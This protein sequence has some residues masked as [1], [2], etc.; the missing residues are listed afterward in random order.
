MIEQGAILVS[1][2][3]FGAVASILACGV[4]WSTACGPDG[5]PREAGS[6]GAVAIPEAPPP[7]P[8]EWAPLV[9]EYA[10]GTDTLSLLEDEQSLYVLFW[11][12]GGQALSPTT[13]STFE[14]SAN[15]GA[16]AVRRNPDG[17]V[18]ELA[19]G[20]LVFQRLSLGGT[21]GETFQIT[22]LRPPEELRA[23][24][25]AALPPE[26]EGDFIPADMVE[27]VSFDPTIRLDVR[28]AS[29]NNFMGE[30]FYSSPRAFLQRPAAEATARAHE[31][32]RERGYGLLIHDGYRPWYVTKMFWDATPET[33]RNFVADPA[34]GSRHN[35]GCAV[36]LTLYDLETG[37]VVMMPAGYDE[38]SPRSN[39]DFP[40]GTTRQRWYRRLLRDA[41][42]A[43]GFSV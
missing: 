17:S 22:P 34:S 4:V 8:T 41:M 35:R 16:L 15:G 43:Q 27:V 36:D 38:M 12:G 33:L 7:P 19:V 20:E 10:T 23:E 30:V 28:Y 2:I 21:E 40:G 37:D 6:E 39:A 26:E 42:E 14:M 5:P 25:L 31:W 24:A 9:G 13:D 18:G 3:R 1:R 11:K 29:T 32:L